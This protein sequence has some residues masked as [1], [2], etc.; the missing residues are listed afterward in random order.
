MAD[1]PVLALDR[2]SRRFNGAPAVDRVSLEVAAGEFFSLLGPSGC[3]K[4]TTLRLIAG[5]DD[6]EP[7][8]GTIRMSGDVVNGLRPY[9]RPVGMV[10][11]NYALFPHLTVGQNVAF[12]LEER[13]LPK[14]DIRRQV[15][16][17]LELVRLDPAAFAARRPA[18]LSG[19]QRQRVALARALVLEPRI[20]L[21][22]EPLAAL[23]LRLR[24]EMRLELRALNRALGITFVLVT[25]DQEEA[26]VMSDRIA[27]MSAGRVEQVGTP[28]EIY[29]HPRTTFVA[30]FIGESNLFDGTV[31]A[32][33][34]GVATVVQPDGGTWC[35]SAGPAVSP[36]QRMCIAVRP[37][38]QV[39]GGADP[40]PAGTNSLP[41]RIRE[42]I[43]QGETV[44][45]LVTLSP[46]RDIR[47][48]LRG[49][50]AAADSSAWHPGDMVTVRWQ[51]CDAQVLEE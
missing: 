13:R 34:G 31:R 44:H 40:V 30:R 32:V 11:Q 18:S 50:P 25:H 28:S 41:G 49:E 2:V 10:F 43:F 9:Q 17:A 6:P 23:D 51:Y 15:D 37:E 1:L 7:D 4:T 29:R 47:V 19:G 48:A 42:I 14:P 46:G 5:F 24:Q 33:D 21:L 35:A 3:G 26:L 22:D 8:G 45:A 12:G 39:L 38:W 20:L 27:V 16:R 36:G